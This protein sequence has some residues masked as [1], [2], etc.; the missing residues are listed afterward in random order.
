MTLGTVSTTT[1][2]VHV[3][4]DLFNQS[5]PGGRVQL[6]V[7]NWHSGV[8]SVGAVFMAPS[9][10]PASG[11]DIFAGPLADVW[12]KGSECHLLKDCFLHSTA[13]DE[14]PALDEAVGFPVQFANVSLPRAAVSVNAWK[15]NS[16]G[17]VNFMATSNVVAPYTSF[18]TSPL[19]HFSPNSMV[20][21]P[22]V[23]IQPPFLPPS[24]LTRTSWLY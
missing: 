21:M 14:Q 20:M 2:H 24:F 9:L 10:A 4:N 12:A 18:Y 19:G 8:S 3:S 15:D 23:R 11:A 6:Y 17:T 5:F 1:V 16:D 22:N 7:T 13:T